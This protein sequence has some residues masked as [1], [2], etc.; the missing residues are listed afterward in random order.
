M[1]EFTAPLNTTYKIECWGASG[2]NSYT[3]GGSYT[4][5]VY[6]GK[7]GYCSGWITF[8]FGSNVYFYV[9]QSG[10][11]TREE[12]FNG[13]GSSGSMHYGRSGGGSTDVRLIEGN[14][15]NDFNSLKSR[16]MVAAGGGGRVK[17]CVL[18]KSVYLPL[19]KNQ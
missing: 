14:A 13:G 18:R 15:W 5:T 2:G 11:N 7:G 6:G 19:G 10:E 12:T 9:G 1:Q 4:N 3:D 17:K 8:P 16:F